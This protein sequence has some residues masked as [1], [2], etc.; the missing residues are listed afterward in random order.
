MR[1][2]SRA[3]VAVTKMGN[4][5]EIS[6][7]TPLWK[8]PTLA[9]FYEHP[10]PVIWTRFGIK[11]LKDIVG[12]GE[13]LQ[14]DALKTTFNLPNTHLF[15]YFQLRHPYNA[16]FGNNGITPKMS[17]IESLLREDTLDKALSTIYKQLFG[18]GGDL[19]AKCRA[20]WGEVFPQMGGDDWDD[21]WDINF[22]RWVS[23]RDQLIQF[24]FLHRIY[25]TPARLA[26]LFPTRSPGCWWCSSLTADFMHIFWNCSNIQ[27]F[28]KG[29]TECIAEVTAIPIQ[30]TIEVC[31]LRLVDNLAPKRVTRTL[32]TILIYY[33]RKMIVLS[34]K[35][36]NPPSVSAWKGVV[37]RAAP[38]Y[39]ATYISRGMPQKFDK[40]WGSWMNSETTVAD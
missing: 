33:A 4:A 31:L 30:L 39:K 9:H 3:W 34:W 8:N 6:P 40:V 29:V 25:L 38:L 35:K 23:A 32:L 11:T 2:T 37:N 28:W 27:A 36:P 20:M 10:V 5:S 13:L 24:K 15:R 18:E 21:V 7:H 1:A 17:D 22:T 14:F 16:Q 19:L 26:R 12:G